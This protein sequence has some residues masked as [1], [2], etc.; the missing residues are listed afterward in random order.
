MR[1]ND[2][3]NLVIPVTDTTRAFH[4]PISEAV[5]EASFRVISAAH[6]ALFADGVDY[7][8]TVGPRVAALLLKDE[9]RRMAEKRGEDGDMGASAVLGEIKRLTT[10]LAPGADGWEML[11]VD[12]AISSGAISAEDWKEAES[13]I[14]FFTFP[15]AILAKNR[16][17]I[18]PI[19]AG[20]LRGTCTASTLS[21]Y[22]D[23]LK[24]STSAEITPASAESSAQG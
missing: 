17:T 23:S 20:V 5:F 2:D 24:A 14:C 15:W 19:F 9:G 10:I 18:A 21:E 3:L 1:I 8:R 12:R 13:A 22:L 11:P 4:T 16:K 7:A 6:A